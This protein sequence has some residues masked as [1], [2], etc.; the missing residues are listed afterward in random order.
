MKKRREKEG[1][2]IKYGVKCLKNEGEWEK[3][4]EKA[5]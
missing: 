4:G 1:N 5:L 3:K 2:C